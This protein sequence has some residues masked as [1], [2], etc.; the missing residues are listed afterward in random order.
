MA[1]LDFIFKLLPIEHIDNFV[2]Y[3]CSAGGLAVLTWTDTIR[4]MLLAKNPKIKFHAL[5]DSGYFVDYKNVQ[6]KEN[7]FNL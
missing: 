3:G 7:D 1:S 2:L 5:A 4:E 6:T